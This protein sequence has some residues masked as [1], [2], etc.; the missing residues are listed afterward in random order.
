MTVWDY[1]IELK[2][3]GTAKPPELPAEAK[4]LLGLQ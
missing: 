2:D 1:S 3:L 4:A